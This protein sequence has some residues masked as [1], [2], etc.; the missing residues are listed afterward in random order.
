[1]QN[2]LPLEKWNRYL[3]ADD[4]FPRHVAMER[5]IHGHYYSTEQEWGGNPN[6]Y[7]NA[8][9]EH[10]LDSNKSRLRQDWLGHVKTA[11]E[12]NAWL[13]QR[14][15]TARRAVDLVKLF[16]E[17]EPR[18]DEMQAVGWYAV[19]WLIFNCDELIR[20]FITE[21]M[22]NS[23]IED[24]P[25]SLLQGLSCFSVERTAAAQALGRNQEENFVRAAFAEQPLPQVI[26]FLQAHY[27]DCYFLQE[28]STFCRTYGL[29]SPTSEDKHPYVPD[30]E[31]VLLMIKNSL[32][33]NEAGMR[34]VNEVLQESAR[35]RQT[36][37]T[38]VRAYLSQHQPDQL[39]RFNKLLDW[40]Q[41][42]TPALD[43]RK[44]HSTMTLRQADLSRRAKAAL[45]EEKLIDHPEDFLLLTQDEWASVVQDPDPEALRQQVHEAQLRY[46]KNRRLE[47]PPYLGKAPDKVEPAEATSSSPIE[48]QKQESVDFSGNK[49]VIQG[50]G[51][52]PGKARGI[53]YKV[54]DMESMG[55]VQ[56]LTSEYILICA[57][58]RF[59][60]QWRR[61][62]YSLFMVVRGLVMVQGPDLHHASQIAR[63]CGIP[64][65]NL[66]ETRFEDLPDRAEIEI[67]GRTGVMTIYK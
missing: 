8:G 12:W 48:Y 61:D 1:M 35:K 53:A 54:D 5:V 32:L 22:P 29:L 39:Q 50:N 18:Q 49:T 51:I 33:K 52:A 13:D 19:Q 6:G 45:M 44:W 62:W 30:V 28:F 46:E 3:T 17:Y 11:Q 25:G 38:Q 60:A 65:I 4:I 14:D 42:W 2:R 59:P 63:E 34:F 47:P 66:P 20:G 7:D 56:G 26:P 9:I 24:L 55:Y 57:P 36:A 21:I 10:W 58:E 15:E 27:P 64:F 40:S 67:N 16:L 41:F 31:G 43:N 23:G 37:E